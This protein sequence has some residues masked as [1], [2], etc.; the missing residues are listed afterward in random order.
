[1]KFLENLNIFL[2]IWGIF[3]ISILGIF[4][5]TN[6]NLFSIIKEKTGVF[7]LGENNFSKKEVKKKLK[8]DLSKY[9]I[10]IKN[11]KYK[12]K[13][14]SYTYLG[15]SF[16]RIQYYI[17]G[18][19]I[20]ILLFSYFLHKT[21]KLSKNLLFKNYVAFLVW[22]PISSIFIHFFGIAIGIIPLQISIGA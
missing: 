6:E 1:M 20:S 3:F 4:F 5:R 15:F 21:K 7:Y 17:L 8:T 2:F 18:Y 22:M 14:V 13:H 12:N 9:N 19:F 10:R 11:Y 16:S